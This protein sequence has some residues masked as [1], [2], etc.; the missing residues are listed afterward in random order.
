MRRTIALLMILAMT[1]LLSAGCATRGGVAEPPPGAATGPEAAATGSD[2]APETVESPTPTISV[3]LGIIPEAPPLRIGETVQV[4]L[5]GIPMEEKD[6]FIDDIGPDGTITLAYLGKVK[7]AG[8]TTAQAAD[9]IQKL[10]VD[11]K[12]YRDVVVRVFATSQ[13]VYVSGKIMRPGRY[14]WSPDLTVSR[15]IELAGDFTEFASHKVQLQRG[16][17]S[18][19]ETI[20]VDAIRKGKSPDVPLFPGDRVLIRGGVF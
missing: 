14:P 5:D 4:T 20:N 10:Y 6:T 9:K 3:D 19:P 11:G 13:F 12:I 7:I 16:G 17:N 2:Q 18:E 15:V 8:L 1:V